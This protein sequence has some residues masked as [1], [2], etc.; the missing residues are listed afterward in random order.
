MNQ[1]YAKG[2]FAWALKGILDTAL[3]VARDLLKA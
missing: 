1:K 3:G 2:E